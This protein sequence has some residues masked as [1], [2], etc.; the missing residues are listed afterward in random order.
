MS[1]FM[2]KPLPRRTVAVLSLTGITACKLV[3]FLLLLKIG[4]VQPYAHASDNAFLIIANHIL[5]TG[6]YNDPDTSKYSYRDP[7]YPFFLALAQWIG[8]HWYLP[9]VVCLQ[10]LL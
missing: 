1:L 6:T 7:G 2:V 8:T 9:L 4:Y 5:T 3:V 10:M